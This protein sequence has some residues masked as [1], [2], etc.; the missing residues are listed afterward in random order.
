M[1]LKVSIIT[2]CYNSSKTIVDAIRSVNIQTYPYIEHIFID[3]LSSDKTVEIIRRNSKRNSK[4]ISEKDNGLYEAVNKG[5]EHASGDIIGFV[6]SDD[7][8][9]S[10][11]VLN[12]IMEMIISKNLDGVYGDLQYVDKKNTK[13]IIRNW[14]SCDFTPGLLK[15]GWMPP[16]PTLF[17]KKEVYEKHGFFN[18]FFEISA[19]YDF[20]LR[21]FK[22]KE[23]QFGYLS[24]VITKMRVGGASNRSFNKIIKKSKEDYWVIRKNKIGGIFTLILKNTSKI[25]QFIS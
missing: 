8:L 11:V 20:I 24:R 21:I 9:E 7:F 5:I 4:I 1:A 3:G 14:K 13:K 19:D 17:L 15:K 16:H 6:H 12:N 2:V 10:D 18:L 23:L 25:K 22:D